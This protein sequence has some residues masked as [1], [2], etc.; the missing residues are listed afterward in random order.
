MVTKIK[1]PIASILIVNFNNKNLLERSIKS[2][3][4]QDYKNC[5]IIIFDDLSTDGSR[6]ELKK[7]K[8]IRIILNQKKTYIPYI[9]AMNAYFKM[10]NVSKGEFIFFFW[11]VMIIFIL[12]KSQ[13]L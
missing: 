8:N 9:D 6:L 4:N 11:I 2:C 12:K 5:E 1:K 3:F 10:F 7:Y 13:L